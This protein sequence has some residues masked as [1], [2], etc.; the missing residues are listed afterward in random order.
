MRSPSTSCARS[1]I[2]PRPR[3][4]PNE[5]GRRA[6]V[7]RLVGLGGEQRFDRTLPRTVELF[8]KLF[9][10]RDSAV[11]EIFERR[12]IAPLV[13]ALLIVAAAAA[14][15]VAAQLQTFFGDLEHAAAAD[16]RLKAAARYIIAQF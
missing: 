10:R 11:N 14:Q 15:P 4:R 9:G 3:M 8:Q 16:H 2:Y 1:T 5:R 12:Q 6:N 7:R 13:A